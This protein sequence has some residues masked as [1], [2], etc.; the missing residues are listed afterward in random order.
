MTL[1]ASAEDKHAYA[2]LGGAIDNL[3][4]SYTYAAKFVSVAD[5]NRMDPLTDTG[6]V[7]N[8]IK[9]LGKAQKAYSYAKKIR[10]A[11]DEKK[12]DGGLLKL[13]I[14]ISVDLA[15]KLLGTSLTTHPYFA[16]HKSMID[17]LADALNASRNSEAAVDGYRRAVTAA[18]STAVAAEFKRLE[19]N[20]VDTV[21]KVE[22]FKDQ[23]G[24]AADIARGAFT[25]DLALERKLIAQYGRKALDD[26]MADL[27]TWRANWAGL[28][29]DVLQ[30]QIMTGHQLNVA[31][32]AMNEVNELIKT[33]MGGSNT[34]RVAGYGAINNIEWEKYD[35]IVNQKKPDL[36]LIDPVKFAQG[37]SDKAAAWGQAFANMCDFV[38]GTDVIWMGKFNL[39]LDSLDKVLYPTFLPEGSR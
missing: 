13:G 15:G 37:N 31:T 4:D 8:Y 16:Y 12:R 14:K 19:S 30:L 20:K 7:A 1:L 34:S 25:Y 9:I 36:S 39:Q 33:L 26:A 32:A 2:K 18:N 28:C 24:V 10:E 11:L 3:S 23:I 17:A 38:R 35:Q 29:F 5:N 6:R 27:E 21:V 22:A